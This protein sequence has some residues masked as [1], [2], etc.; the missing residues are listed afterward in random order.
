MLFRELEQIDEALARISFGD[1][2][3][4]ETL[5]PRRAELL[6]RLVPLAC[7]TEHE[8]ALRRSRHAAAAAIRQ[9]CLARNQI[10]QEMYRLTQEQRWRESISA[11][12][13]E[14]S[15]WSLQA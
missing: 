10:V 7:T 6:S 5:L 8:K 11:Q 15:N 3:G 14:R 13:S 1:L 2:A 9:V 4:L 12:G